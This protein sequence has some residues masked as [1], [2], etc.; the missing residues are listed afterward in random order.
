[1]SES[2]IVGNWKMNGSRAQLAEFAAGWAPEDA[3]ATVVL[4]PPYP[5]L[6][7]MAEHLPGVGL[8]AQD[9]SANDGG[10][11]TGEVAADMLV[12]AGC[13]WVILG[14]SERREYH[15]ESDALVAEKLAAALA[16][17]LRPIVC[18]GETLAQRE[19]GEHEAVVSAQVLGS[20]GEADLSTVVVAYEPVWAIGTG[21]TATPE[22]ANAMH[23]T[24]RALLVERFGDVGQRIPLLY[25]GSVKPGNAA[26]LFACEFID[27]ALVGGASLKAA[28][29]AA[30]VGAA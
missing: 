24:I 15:G 25:G 7:L 12:D 19:A 27:G 26:E 11:F 21:V 23:G 9:C 10:A 30:I 2:I 6:P 22:Q 3:S 29:F 4:A 18:V 13:Q 16:S 1:M 14:H 8:A 17:G 20:L 5:Y 28:D